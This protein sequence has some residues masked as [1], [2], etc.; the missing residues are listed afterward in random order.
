MKTVIAL[1]LTLTTSSVFATGYNCQSNLKEAAQKGLVADQTIQSSLKTYNT[2]KEDFY[3][4]KFEDSLEAANVAEILRVKSQDLFFQVRELLSNAIYCNDEVLRN[5]SFEL[6]NLAQKNLKSIDL[7]GEKLEEM[8]E[9]LETMLGEKTID[10]IG[11]II[12]KVDGE[13]N[14]MCF[15][16][17]MC[18]NGMVVTCQTY[19]QGCSWFV[20]N[21][22]VVCNGYN[23]Y[24]QWVT[25]QGRCW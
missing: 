16:Q 11:D 2:A 13:K 22:A 20:T 15:G 10:V 5:K 1:F 17:T 6:S 19:G 8:I 18:P 21:G 7:Y 14:A 24:G 12:M 23:Q 25:T 9:G 3:A 4:E